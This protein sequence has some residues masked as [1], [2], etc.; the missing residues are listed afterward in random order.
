MIAISPILIEALARVANEMSNAQDAHPTVM[1]YKQAF[2]DELKRFEGLPVEAQYPP[3][4]PSKRVSM[5]PTPKSTQST[6]SSLGKGLGQQTGGTAQS[7][8][9]TIRDLLKRLSNVDDDVI[10]AVCGAKAETFIRDMR[11]QAFKQLF[12]A[13]GRQVF[14]LRDLYHQLLEK[15][16]V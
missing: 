2:L 9:D 12:T 8:A 15:G 6:Q 4:S 14:H 11:G 3:Q 5:M 1:E 13:T 16:Y 7:D 10:S